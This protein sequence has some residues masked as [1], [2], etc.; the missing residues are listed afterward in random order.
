MD[1]H[2]PVAAAYPIGPFGKGLLMT[3]RMR[4]LFDQQRRRRVIDLVMTMQ[5]PQTCRELLPERFTELFHIGQ[6]R[7]LVVAVGG[8]FAV[9]PTGAV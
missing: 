9:D 6:I 2:A 8:V 5:P 4:V 3:D 7:L 1:E